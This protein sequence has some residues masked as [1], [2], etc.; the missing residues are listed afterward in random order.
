MLVMTRADRIARSAAHLLTTVQELK[1]GVA[2]QFLDQPEL[3]TEGK[4]AD[5]LSPSSS[6]TSWT[7]SAATALPLPAP[8]ACDSDGRGW[9]APNCWPKPLARTYRGVTMPQIARR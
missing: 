3:S 6:A 8:R 2:I 4:F 1:K 5:F 7:R 9:S